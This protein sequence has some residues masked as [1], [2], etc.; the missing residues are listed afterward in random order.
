M[1]MDKPGHSKSKVWHLRPKTRNTKSTI[2]IQIVNDNDLYQNENGEVMKL[3]T[4]L[5]NHPPKE[6]K[7]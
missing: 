6:M 5:N 3:L 7:N 2:N 1:V 4:I